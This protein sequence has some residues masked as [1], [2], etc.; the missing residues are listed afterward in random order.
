[1]SRD[2]VGEW[3]DGTGSTVSPVLFDAFG[4]AQVNNSDPVTPSTILGFNPYADLTRVLTPLTRLAYVN[5]SPNRDVGF[6]PRYRADD[7]V[8]GSWYSFDTSNGINLYPYVGN[9]P[10]AYVDPNG[11][12]TKKQAEALM[13][14]CWAVYKYL[15]GHPPDPRPPPPPAPIQRQLPTIPGPPPAP[16]P[17][18]P[19]PPP[20]KP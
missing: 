1:V 6:T 8:G 10:T 9:N 13:A 18:G 7:S 5:L 11:D 20:P 14:L 19:P 17:R 15:T 12:L 3:S 4:S 16:P 2:P